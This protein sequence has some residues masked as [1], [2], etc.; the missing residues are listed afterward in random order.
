MQHRSIANSG[1]VF[2]PRRY[3]RDFQDFFGYGGHFRGYIDHP[4][5]DTLQNLEVAELKAMERV[6]A[7]FKD[8]D[9]DLRETLMMKVMPA[10]KNHTGQKLL[11]EVE[12]AVR[13]NP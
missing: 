8:L 12:A 11:A 5:R 3:Q 10:T 6:S 7:D 1:G 4:T 13:Y 9:Q 2:N